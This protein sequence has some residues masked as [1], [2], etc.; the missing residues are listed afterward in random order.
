[1]WPEL[2]YDSVN[3]KKGQMSSQ[4][5]PT[6]H[7]IKDTELTLPIGT[8]FKV[9]FS[10]SSAHFSIGHGSARLEISQVI[11]ESRAVVFL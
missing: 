8:V 4:V 5:S 7:R 11:R 9:N 2:M 10:C 1:M 6:Q 3:S